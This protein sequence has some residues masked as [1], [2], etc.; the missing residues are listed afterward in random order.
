M[1]RLLMV[2]ILML[3]VMATIA[4]ARSKSRAT[5][6]IK[7]AKAD[8]TIKTKQKTAA[9]TP[10]ILS[11]RNI[12]N[13]DLKP[14]QATQPAIGNTNIQQQKEINKAA[15]EVKN[16][17]PKVTI[18]GP[19][20]IVNQVVELPKT[21]KLKITATEVQCIKKSNKH[22]LEEY[23]IYQTVS[24]VTQG[25]SKAPVEHSV[26]SKTSKPLEYD[27]IKTGYSRQGEG[28]SKDHFTKIQR[29]NRFKDI[30]ENS[31]V[32]TDNINEEK[33][34]PFKA[35]LN[36]REGKN[37]DNSFIYTLSESEVNDPQAKMVIH[38]TL[39][40]YSGRK[41]LDYYSLLVFDYDSDQ[42]EVSIKDVLAILTGKRKLEATKKYF[43]TDIAK[44]I[45]FDDF[46]GFNLN[47]RKVDYPDKI[48]LEGP[49]RKRTNSGKEKAAVWM[50]FE[51]VE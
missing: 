39:G 43:D 2:C 48:I 44:G 10:V 38:T 35:G 32:L 26:K 47:L 13:V 34:Y 27:K 16:T 40:E 18:T 51:L 23:K 21:Y 25:I 41:H 12:K 3:L 49:I 1:K 33:A 19:P 11:N 30:P 6:P 9:Q 7:K 29:Y 22:P 20:I 15:E 50:R 42:L 5:L 28:M 37:I 45:L 36:Q 17:P 31:Y 24:Y 46:G 8:T 14:V 4:Q